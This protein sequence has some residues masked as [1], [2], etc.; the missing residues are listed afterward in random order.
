MRLPYK[1]VSIIFAATTL[2][3]LAK[4]HI[5]GPPEPPEASHVRTSKTIS[6]LFWGSVVDNPAMAIFQQACDDFEK[7]RPEIA[8]DLSF[9]SVEQ[10]KSKLPVLMA[11]NRPPDLFMTWCGA[12]IQPFIEAG[13]VMPLNRFLHQSA[14]LAD[15]FPPG[16]FDL[17]THEGLTYGIPT[18]RAVAA[19]FY[20]P[21]I[22]QNL[23]LSLPQTRSELLTAATKLRSQGIVPVALGNKE[24]WVGGMLAGQ[25]IYQNQGS[26][27]F[28]Q[29]KAGTVSWTH[30]AFVDTAELIQ[31]LLAQGTFP[32]NP[33]TVGYSES[34]DL[35]YT[36][37]AAML[38]MG[39]WF[40]Q[41]LIS[42]DTPLGDAIG[43]APFPLLTENPETGVAWMG[44]T[45]MNIA[46]SSKCAH[47]SEAV[48]LI[49]WLTR[50]VYQR[51]LMID[52]GLLPATR[53][54]VDSE[55]VRPELLELKR[56]IAQADNIAIFPDIGLGGQL[57]KQFNSSIQM[58]FAG[59]DP[60]TV[61]ERLQEKT[62][63]NRRRASLP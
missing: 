14:E 39:S 19:L 63:E 60:Q 51:S 20:H 32:D 47:T 23:G 17:L 40:I 36:K 21:D 15:R 62:A 6:V 43:V 28:E 48:E 22:F 44:Q 37:K 46:I 3:I 5:F 30:R 42:Q 26:L 29:V 27:I 11:A 52:A 49:E 57:G 58:V 31:A 2:I 38:L 50:P 45:D 54:T 12:Y 18:T 1:T 13:K 53:V 16:S 59:Q 8:V 34:I 33:N 7:E 4:Q 55:Q 9:Y 41:H 56:L 35:F 10:Y 25:L 24:P 61:F